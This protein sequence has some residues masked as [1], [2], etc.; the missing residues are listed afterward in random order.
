MN[1]N[2][3]AI[4]LAA[5]KSTRFNTE[6]TK[7]AA[8]ICGQAMI[9]FPTKLLHSLNIPTTVVVGYQQE[10]VKEIITRE[11]NDTINFVT[12]EKQNGTGHALACTKELW[13]KNHILVM[14]G[15]VPLITPETI[16]SLYAEHIKN[17]AAMSFVTS[18]A[19]DTA[20]KAY[21]RV[22]K[23]NNNISIV[24][25]K[26][27][28]G[29]IHEQH[30]INAGIY[31]INK[32][33]L[34]NYIATL[35]DNNA[36]KEFYITDL[37]K[38]ASQNNLAV[39]TIKA[40]FDTIRGINTFQE[41]YMT[42]QIKRTELVNYWMDNGVHFSFPQHVHL[43][44][45]VTIGQGSSIGTGVHLRKNSSIG[46]NCTVKEFSCLENVIVEDNV[47]I[48]QHCVI[49]NSYIKT[50][51]EVGPFAHLRSNVTIGQNS[52]VGNFVEIKNSTIDMRTK[53]KHLSYIGDSTIGSHVNIGAGTIT[54]NYDGINK[55]KTIIKDHAFIGS[56]NAIIAP[57]TIGHNAFTA[58]GSTITADVPD[59]ALAIARTQQTNK[60]DYA[61]KLKAL[62]TE[63]KKIDNNNVDDFS[64]IGARVIYPTTPAD[65][66]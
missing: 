14:N 54:C 20:G 55:H 34:H 38:I 5:G 26:D 53:A 4:I 65:E 46:N 50:T 21:G 19:P 23:T 28:T 45:N 29:D 64:F 48:H 35:N 18:R 31:L 2:V 52:I 57:V 61:K 1:N 25:A 9:L 33:F 58:A 44:L 15:D 37:V 32:N 30:D 62:T 17:S 63:Q 12:Q 27:F 43:D 24:E 47:T 6:K 3:Q 8:D 56:N 60:Y 16:T 22:I 66:Q 41:L 51:A 11:H 39:T 49:K 40:P 42:E 10:T 36:S 7:L 13:D 59:N